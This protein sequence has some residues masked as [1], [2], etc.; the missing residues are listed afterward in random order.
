MKIYKSPPARL[1]DY[2]RNILKSLID[3][4]IKSSAS[5]ARSANLNQGAMVDAIGG[6]RSINYD[7]LHSLMNKIGLDD[8]WEL[9]RDIP[10]FFNLSADLSPILPIV[11]RLRDPLLWWT[12]PVFSPG[13]G[14]VDMNRQALK[15]YFVI[16]SADGHLIIIDRDPWRIG[17]GK[18]ALVA[19]KDALPFTPDHIQ[20]LQ[21]NGHDVNAAKLNLLPNKIL[22]IMDIFRKDDNYPNKN[23]LLH[24]LFNEES[25]PTV[26]NWD[27]VISYA[28]SS[29]ISPTDVMQWMVSSR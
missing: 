6:N 18:K 13:P 27:D 3:M 7:S 29:K 5:I 11:E 10:H 26:P 25:P 4:N 28:T 14:V 16:R 15:T 2:E 17:K 20:N 21:W 1:A 9:R 24:M 22:P 23:T 19:A 12:P 8:H